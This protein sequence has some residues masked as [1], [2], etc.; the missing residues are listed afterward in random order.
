MLYTVYKNSWELRKK[1]FN[2]MSETDTISIATHWTQI[3]RP[4]T[5]STVTLL[6]YHVFIRSACH[7]VSVLCTP[8]WDFRPVSR[9]WCLLWWFYF[10]FFFRKWIA[11]CLKHF[12]LTKKFHYRWTNGHEILKI[13]CCLVKD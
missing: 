5:I 11:V 6:P 12:D 9:I 3:C 4:Q 13:F 1:Y 8:S 7:V 10:I 2:W